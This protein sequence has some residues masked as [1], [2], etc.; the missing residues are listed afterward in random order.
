M[1]VNHEILLP[2]DRSKP[3]L[4]LR[5]NLNNS[6]AVNTLKAITPQLKINNE[7]LKSLLYHGETLTKIAKLNLEG[8][9]GIDDNGIK[10]FVRQ[11]E[12]LYNLKVLK[13]KGTQVGSHGIKLILNSSLVYTLEVLDTRDCSMEHGIDELIDISKVRRYQDESFLFELRSKNPKKT[14]RKIC[15]IRNIF[16]GEVFQK[17][18]EKQRF[19]LGRRDNILVWIGDNMVDR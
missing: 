14:R 15:L 2:P 3:Q 13:L 7:V 16:E 5:S 18:L 17:S 19:P 8:F 11:D 12:K 10:Y 4:L 9:K 6:D 1:K